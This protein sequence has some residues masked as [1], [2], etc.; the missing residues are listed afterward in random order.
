VA[1]DFAIQTAIY[2]RLSSFAALTALLAR[3]GA[4]IYDYVPQ[5][6]AN[7]DDEFPYLV[8]GEIEA[9][10][11]DADDRLGHDTTVTIHSFSRYRGKK[12]CADIMAQVYEALHRYAL[13]VTGFSLVDCHWDGLSRIILDPDGQTRHG[14]QRFRVIVTKGA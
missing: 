4:A 12:E 8:I 14:V 6:L 11:F 5:E 2:S 3:S 1:A 13:T 10:E 7:S 9:E